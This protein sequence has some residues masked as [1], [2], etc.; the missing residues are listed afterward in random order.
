M[1]PERSRQAGFTLLEVLV[2]L[3]LLGAAMAAL[4]SLASVGRRANRAEVERVELAQVARRVLAE[5]TA[6]N[7]AD[8]TTGA[9]DGY[10]WRIEAT[11]MAA[12]PPPDRG[13]AP[14]ESFGQPQQA[15]PPQPAWIPYRIV[16]RVTGP[17]GASTEIVTVRLARAAS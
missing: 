10:A 1:R 12:P 5:M 2:T 9:A 17:G 15:K 8:A 11:R 16:L 14:I 4:G 3:A 13:P 6:R 7:F